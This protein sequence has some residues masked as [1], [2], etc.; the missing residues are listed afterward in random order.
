MLEEVWDTYDWTVG[1]E[2]E[3]EEEM[4]VVDQQ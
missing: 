3:E 1:L 2:E 4:V